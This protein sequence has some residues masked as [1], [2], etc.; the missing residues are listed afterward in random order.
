MMKRIPL[1]LAVASLLASC[2]AESATNAQI[3]SS[4]VPLSQTAEAAKVQTIGSQAAKALLDQKKD[5][6]VLD[7]RTPGEF[8]AGH[9]ANAQ[10]LDF[11]QADFAQKLK[12]LDPETPYLVYCAVGGRSREAVRMMQQLGFQQVYDATEGYAALKNAGVSVE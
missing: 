4:A 7:I 8:N 2:S 6:V 10:H 3:E 1:I 11:Y 5:V 9:L 12:A